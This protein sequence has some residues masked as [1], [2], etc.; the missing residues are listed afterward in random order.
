MVGSFGMMAIFTQ[1]SAMGDHLLR[2]KSA[3]RGKRSRHKTF[4][5]RELQRFICVMA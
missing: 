2:G 1:G 5:T 4:S 3:P